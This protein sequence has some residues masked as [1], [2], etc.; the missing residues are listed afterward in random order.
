VLAHVHTAQAAEDIA[1]KPYSK[2]GA[3][4]ESRPGREYNH[5]VEQPW[6]DRQWQEDVRAAPHSA[7]LESGHQEHTLLQQ[8]R[9]QMLLLERQ[10]SVALG[11]HFGASCGWYK[12][13]ARA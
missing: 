11:V 8:H 10:V 13:V 6:A 2:A 9:E 7:P 1:N 5:A 4:A 3:G 12:L